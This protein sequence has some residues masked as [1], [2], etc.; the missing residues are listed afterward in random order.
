MVK[1]EFKDFINLISNFD[2]KNSDQK[3]EL[4][5]LVFE[6]PYFQLAHALY[7]K[8]LKIQDQFNFDLILKKTAILSPK[9][10]L[11]F[12]WIENKENNFFKIFKKTQAEKLSYLKNRPSHA[13]KTN[14]E[15]ES[16]LEEK[17]MHFVDWVSSY[18]KTKINL[19]ISPL[20][21]KIQMIDSF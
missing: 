13:N 2:P 8:S 17:R 14:Q 1:K 7:L 15:K 10:K 5:N 11:I 21:S 6:Y 9:R 16:N 18:N 3:K 12:N 19:K 20:D 4:E